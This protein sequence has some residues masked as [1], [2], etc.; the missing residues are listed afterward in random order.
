MDDP[1]YHVFADGPPMVAPYSHAVETGQWLFVTGQMPIEPDGTI[2][3]TIEAQ[4]EVVFR[5]LRAVM[6]RAGFADGHVVAARVYLT[7]FAEHYERMNAVYARQFPEGRYP[8]RTC[9]GV[10]GLAR[11]CDVEIDLVVRRRRVR[12]IKARTRP[13]A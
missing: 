6:A 12:A 4:T 1:V 7:H 9:I 8:A 2:P 10:T 3:A 5:N 13:P 11:G